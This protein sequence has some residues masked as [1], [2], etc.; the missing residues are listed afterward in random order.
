L[1]QKLEDLSPKKLG[2]RLHPI[3]IQDLGDR[4]H[5]PRRDRPVTLDQIT[6]DQGF[7]GTAGF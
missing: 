6:S 1:S 2:G 5:W 4:S 3:L 7:T